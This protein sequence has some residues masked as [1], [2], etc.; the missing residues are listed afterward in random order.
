MCLGQYLH[1]CWDLTA[2][3][4]LYVSGRSK[5]SAD[6]VSIGLQIQHSGGLRIQDLPG[7]CKTYQKLYHKHSFNILEIQ[8]NSDITLKICQLNVIFGFLGLFFDHMWSILMINNLLSGKQDWMVKKG[9]IPVRREQ[10]ERRDLC[11]KL[12]QVKMIS[13]KVEEI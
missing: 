7:I 2:Q 6:L 8:N 13:L 4:E 11:L 5:F 9:K 3:F 10:D 1:Y 12:G